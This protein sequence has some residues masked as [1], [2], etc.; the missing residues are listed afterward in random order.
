MAE[1]HLLMVGTR[2]MMATM[3]PVMMRAIEPCWVST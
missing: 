3:L 1:Q 2:L